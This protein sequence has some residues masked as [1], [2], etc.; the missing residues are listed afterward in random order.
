MRITIYNLIDLRLKNNYIGNKNYASILIHELGWKK[1][2]KFLIVSSSFP[3]L[4]RVTES[5]TRN[6]QKTN[7]NYR[8]K[9]GRHGIFIWNLNFWNVVNDVLRKH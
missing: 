2:R 1:E 4:P 6:K 8:P 5:C 3:V 7:Q 9:P